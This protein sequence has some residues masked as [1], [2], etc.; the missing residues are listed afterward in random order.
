[1]K[2]VN[3]ET[4]IKQ[5]QWRYAT[6]Q[7]DPAR[8]IPAEDWKTLEHA[9]L[10]APLSFGLQPYKFVV[11]PRTRRFAEL[12]EVSWGQSQIVDASHLVVFAA[13]TEVT[14]ADVTAYVARIAAVRGV[15]VEG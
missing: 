14:A 13:K 9:M 3:N 6:K 10:L 5:L 8:K 15:P 12:C 2:P 7:F 1:M 4:I 11:G